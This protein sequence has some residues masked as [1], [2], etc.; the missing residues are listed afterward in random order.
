MIEV[1]YTDDLMLAKVNNINK[2]NRQV[3]V[4]LLDVDNLGTIIPIRNLELKLPSFDNSILKILKSSSHVII[5]TEGFSYE[6]N[7][8]IVSAINLTDDELNNEKENMIKM[9]NNKINKG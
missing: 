5:F 9:A 6:N 1:S 3:N 8:T 2:K 4:T 7:S